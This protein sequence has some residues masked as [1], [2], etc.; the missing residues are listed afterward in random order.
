MSEQY[1]DKIEVVINPYEG[2]EVDYRTWKI[3]RI[4]PE[5]GNL[6][7][8]QRV[9]VRYK[10]KYFSFV[11]DEDCPLLEVWSCDDNGDLLNRENIYDLT[12]PGNT[13]YEPDHDCLGSGG[14]PPELYDMPTP[15]EIDQLSFGDNIYGEEN[16][17]NQNPEDS[18]GEE[19]KS[20]D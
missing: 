17:F 18:E 2:T 8:P 13:R 7:E 12:E 14:P 20:L 15:E 11:L 6:S 5:T 3:H 9:D 16:P 19:W 10:N 1:K 4:N